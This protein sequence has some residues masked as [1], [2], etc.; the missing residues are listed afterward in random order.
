MIAREKAMTKMATVSQSPTTIRS[1]A[2]PLFVSPNAS[3][4]AAEHCPWA[5]AE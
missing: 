3:Q 5:T 4:L 2:N 1:W